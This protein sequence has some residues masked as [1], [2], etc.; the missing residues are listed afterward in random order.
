MEKS[1]SSGFALREY[2]NQRLT[3]RTKERHIELGTARFEQDE[4]DAR[5]IIICNY[6]WLPELWE[7]G[8]PITN[9]AT[10]EIATDDMKN[11]RGEIA[12]W[13]E[14]KGRKCSRLI[15]WKIYIGE[16]KI[17]LLR[18][19]KATTIEINW[20][21]N[22]KEEPLNTRGWRSIVHWNFRNVRDEKTWFAQ[23]NGLLRES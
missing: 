17:T 4:E 21:E 6:A 16:H 20:E 9:F 22:N 1:A 5:N 2:L 7:K 11:E 18:S 15:C 14:E 23:N 13:Y 10:G 3:K 19:N 12:H 8:H